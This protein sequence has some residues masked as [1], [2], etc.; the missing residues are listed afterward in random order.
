MSRDDPNGARGRDRHP[1]VLERLRRLSA[2]PAGRIAKWV[3]LGVWIV[4]FVVAANPASKFEDAQQNES[5]SFLPGDAESTKVLQQVEQFDQRPGEQADA[6][7]VYH[8]DGGLTAVDRAA[9][10][11]DRASLNAD[12]P[13]GAVATG[14]PVFATDG[15]S[16]LLITPLFIEEG[17][18]DALVDAV[19]DIRDRVHEAPEGLV[20]KVTG[21]AGYSA[22]AIKVFGDINS[23]LLLAT[24]LIVF[25]L[26]VLIYRSPIFWIIPLLSVAFAEI[27]V[28]AI[29][30]GLAEAGVV[31]NGQTA[32]ILLVLVF[33]VGTDYALLLVSRYREELRRHED[34][35]EAMA[36]ALRRAGP[37][38][39]ASGVTNICALLVLQIAEVNGTAGLGPVAAIGVATALV[40][41]LTILPALLVIVGRGAFWP[42]IP[43]YQPEGEVVVPEEHGFFRRL[44]DGIGRRPRPVWIASVVA[45]AVMSC[46]LVTFDTNL[47]SANSFRDDVEAVQGQELLAESFPAGASAPTDVIVPDRARVPAVVAALSR[48]EGV[49]AARPVDVGPPGTR[50]AV[51]LVPNPYST[52]AFDLIPDLRDVAKQAG[53]PDTLVGGPTATEYDL[54]VASE[55]DL[56]VIPPIVLVVIAVIIGLLLRAIVAPL[57]LIATVILS[58]LAAL[59]VSALAFDWIFDFP[60]EDASLPLFGFIFLVAV[61]VDYNI[62]LMARVREEAARHGTHEGMIRG[63]AVTGAVITS[64]GIVLAGTFAVLGVLPLVGLTEIGF[65]VAFG[66]LL[67]TI[68][69]R[70]VLVPA[71]VMEIGD[72][73]W[74]PSRLVRRAARAAGEAPAQQRPPPPPEPTGSRP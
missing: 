68:L 49:S 40:A 7:T 2:V 44:G 34:R 45:L 25:V 61:G 11:R 4:I 19:D 23:T 9:I 60:G 3:V 17:D 62:F 66:I 73:V 22:D 50:L 24:A 47:T 43:R 42:F 27:T 16:A 31:I 20:V 37:A 13:E 56:K 57:I 1:G 29:G 54:R 39:L 32:G 5:T 10:A 46:G 69:V 67:D 65:L 21:G 28:R 38:I 59:G 58:F 26:L 53:G 74:W 52:E 15:T 35:H 72:H 12:R 18:S 63:L 8:R 70:S 36:L 55:R 64:A 6:V 33:G 41:M 71:L 48:T 30:Y 14:P 51:T